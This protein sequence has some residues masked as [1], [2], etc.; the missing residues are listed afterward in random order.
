MMLHPFLASVVRARITTGALTG[1][2]LGIV[3]L[4]LA[5]GCGGDF[6]TKD[7]TNDPA[8]GDFRNV[9]G[10]W[11]TKSPLWLKESKNTL[12]LETSG[13]H[14][15]NPMRDVATLPAGTKIRIDHLIFERTIETEFL[16]ATGSL[17]SGPY[18]G[19]LVKFDNRLFAPNA[20][21]HPDSFTTTQPATGWPRTWAVAP[22]KLQK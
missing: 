22:D 7:V 19:R 2:M 18:A 20:F 21:K 11:E 1:A 17:T 13:E 8:Y 12:Y 3:Y 16:Y 15:S 9:V 6:G 5:M 10:T 4:L 14:Y